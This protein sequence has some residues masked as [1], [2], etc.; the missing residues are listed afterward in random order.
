VDVC[1]TDEICFK[2]MF[3]VLSEEQKHKGVEYR[4][5]YAF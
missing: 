3:Y 4:I 2:Y 5:R 1:I